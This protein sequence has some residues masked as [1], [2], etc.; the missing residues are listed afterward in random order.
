MNDINTFKDVS[1]FQNDLFRSYQ[2]DSSVD[3]IINSFDNSNKWKEI[4][5]N[6]F[7][8]NRLPFDPDKISNIDVYI[9]IIIIILNRIQ[10]IQNETCLLH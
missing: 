5:C 4:S 8:P 6:P 9:I 3:S 7:P 1:E 10:E 2:S